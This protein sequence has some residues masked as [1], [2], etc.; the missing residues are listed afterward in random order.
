MS[1]RNQPQT[2][3]QGHHPSVTAS[4]RARTAEKEGAFLLPYLKP[5]H[6][7]LDLGCGPGTITTGLAKYVPEGTITGVDTTPEILS[8]ARTLHAQHQPPAPQNVT[9]L[10]AD[11]LEGLPFADASFDVVFCS[12]VLLHIP[13]PVAALRE[14]RRVCRPGGG[15]VACREG[16]WPFHFTPYLPGLALWNK[17]TWEL[18]YGKSER[19]HPDQP[20]QPEG[21]RSG[22]LVHKWAR[23]AGF[24]VG[25]M[26]KG[27]GVELHASEEE[28][29]FYRDIMVGR[30]EEGGHREKYMKLGATK[31]QVDMMVADFKRWADD[32]DGWHAV[33]QCEV[34][35]YA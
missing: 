6:H 13:D 11:V 1:N 29:R 24:G 22:S 10:Q 9:F 27:A 17:Y 34:V 14:M 12:Q 5:T 31:E 3:M 20:P 19:E 18:L 21:H 16:E 23:E 4:H 15:I 30:I 33:L 26:V 8:Q 7:I 2:Y 28:R 32:V 35:C 25:G